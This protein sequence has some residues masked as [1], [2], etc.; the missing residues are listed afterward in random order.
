M[1]K[2]LINSLEFFIVLAV[3]F[4]VISFMSHILMKKIRLEAMFL[5]LQNM[6]YGLGNI[7]SSFIG[8]ITPFCVCTTIP[9]FIGMSQ[10][11]VSTN[12]AMSFLFSSPLLSI[13]G[14]IL[15]FYL[16]GIKFFIYYVIAILIFS[17]MGG[18]FSRFIDFDKG[19]NEDMGTGLDYN[20]SGSFSNALVFSSK[21]FKSLLI[22]LVIG[23]VIAG[24]IH[25]YVPVRLIEAI[26]QYPVWVTIPL[27]ALIGFP[28]YSNILVLAPI[29]FSL[30]EKGMN[31]GAVMTFLISGAGISL[32][33]AI[34]LK[35][36]L[37]KKLYYYYLI[38][39]FIAYCIIGMI[40]NLI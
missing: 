27:A 5:S 7:V 36:I 22:P 16:F 15:I 19:I 34:V 29:C 35:K 33:T 9:I 17:I 10:M 11:G 21:L 30:V 23:A 12:V 28:I 24:F 3:S 14:G 38:Y 8:A 40:F 6:G 4:L 39:T 31:Q 18:I 32:P 25:N 1:N 26:N 13:S 2:I 20:N 37:K